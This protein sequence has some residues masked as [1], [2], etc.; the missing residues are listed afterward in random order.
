M[1]VAPAGWRHVPLVH[2]TC[3]NAGV[4]LVRGAFCLM[5]CSDMPPADFQLFH[6]GQLRGLVR[7]WLVGIA[8][9]LSRA[10][11]L[12]CFKQLRRHRRRGRC[13]PEQTSRNRVH[14][15]VCHGLREYTVHTT[16][17]CSYSTVT[18][19]Q[20]TMTLNGATGLGATQQ[21]GTLRGIV[22]RL[23]LCALLCRR[24]CFCVRWLRSLCQRR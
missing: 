17:W 1:R 7:R 20:T 8:E 4:R 13:A 18:I 3:Y 6:D 22:S 11:G 2:H 5:H 24:R 16:G 23:M 15:S 9:E 12:R 14:R 19:Q 10:A 21:V